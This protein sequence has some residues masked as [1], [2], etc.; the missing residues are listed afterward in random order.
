VHDYGWTMSRA[1]DGAIT[2]MPPLPASHS[3]QARAPNLHPG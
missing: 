3:A 1:A 2:V